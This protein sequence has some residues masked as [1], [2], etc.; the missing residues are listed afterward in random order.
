MPNA[1]A[2]QTDVVIRLRSYD[3]ARVGNAIIEKAQQRT[4][5]AFKQ[6]GINTDWVA[7]GEPQ[8]RIMIIEQ[9]GA[10]L[11]ASGDVCGY[12][13]REA[14]GTS[15]RMAYVA[16]GSIRAFVR[17]PQSGR[18]RLDVSDMLGYC[19]AHEIGHLLLPAGSHSPTGIMRARWRENDFT[20]MA[21]GTLL[22]A[23]S[24]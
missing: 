14:D 18:A 6:V 20:L 22:Q 16:Y 13:P 2:S 23:R 24:S 11:P 1:R 5:F 21:T 7:D 9:M 15:G 4:A 10:I 8:F 3:Y 12:T 17:N 19:I